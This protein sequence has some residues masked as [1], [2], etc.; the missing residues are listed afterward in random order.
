MRLADGDESRGVAPEP[1]LFLRLWRA[2]KKNR[3]EIPPPH[4]VAQGRLILRPH[5]QHLVDEKLRIIGIVRLAKPRQEIDLVDAGEIAG[6][7]AAIFLAPD[8]I[9][10]VIGSDAVEEAVRVEFRVENIVPARDVVQGRQRVFEQRL[11]HGV[12]DAE[13]HDA[14]KRVGGPLVS[15]DAARVVVKEQFFVPQMREAFRPPVDGAVVGGEMARCKARRDADRG[16]DVK[17]E[18]GSFGEGRLRLARRIGQLMPAQGREPEAEIAE[19]VEGDVKAFVRVAFAPQRL[20]MNA[21][22]LRQRALLCLAG[23]FDGG[24]VGLREIDLLQR[25]V[26]IDEPGPD[27]L[28]K[29]AGV[30]A[31]RRRLSLFPP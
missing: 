5:E 12:R 15:E 29:A 17:A 20:D 24:A 25:R 8:P 21:A 4:G 1:G 22:L 16:A 6:V 27:P 14:H 19:H 10:L 9:G 31:H 26:E 7:C 13:R 28:V 11:R 30:F 18:R 3:E 2:F 23:C